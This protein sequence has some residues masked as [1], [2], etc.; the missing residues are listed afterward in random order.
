MSF[1]T[2]DLQRRFSFEAKSQKKGGRHWNM[3]ASASKSLFILSV[4][5]QLYVASS[6]AWNNTIIFIIL[7]SIQ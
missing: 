3:L 2:Q 7:V 5:R 1:Y 6:R 4:H